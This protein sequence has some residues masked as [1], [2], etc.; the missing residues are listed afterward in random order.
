[1]AMVGLTNKIASLP[2]LRQKTK[3]LFTMKNMKS[4]KGFCPETPFFK[5]VAET[6]PKA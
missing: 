2:M 5:A 3:A 1:M 6:M 4:L